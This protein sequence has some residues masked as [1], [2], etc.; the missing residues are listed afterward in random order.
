MEFK[1][2]RIRTRQLNA[3]LHLRRQEE[4]IRRL[5]K[6]AQE[7][8]VCRNAILPEEFVEEFEKLFLRVRYE[9]SVR[10][11]RSFRRAYT[12]W[13]AAQKMMLTIRTE[14]SEWFFNM[15]TIYDYFNSRQLSLYYIQGIL[16]MANLWGFFISRKLGKPFL[17]V[18]APRGFERQRLLES[19]YQ[20]RN[21]RKPSLPLTPEM[22]SGA[23]KKMRPANFNF[24]F[25]TVWFGLRPQEVDNL[26]RK[27]LW[28]IEAMNSGRRVLK[29]YQTKIVALPPEDRWKPIPILYT[30]QEFGLR[31]ILSGNFRRP[32]SKTVRRHFGPGHDL[33]AGRKGFV[34]LMLSKGHSIENICIWMGHCT[35]D[36]TW[37]S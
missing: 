30:D 22:L 18:T 10:G 29:R 36:R 8:R 15:R 7:F 19:F 24:L 2:A 31:I 13:N 25:L 26:H 27:S 20:K 14:P 33:Y 9:K 28:A 3:E 6:K 1:E 32:L 12:I 34:D 17:P 35:L 23:R 21:R 37:R 5:Q 16:R 4:R 11:R